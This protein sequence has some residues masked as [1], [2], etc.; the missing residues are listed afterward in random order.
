MHPTCKYHWQS[1][2]LS[3]IFRYKH[4]MLF[5]GSKLSLNFSYWNVICSTLNELNDIDIEWI[6][7]QEKH[8]LSL[9]QYSL[10]YILC[11]F[12]MCTCGWSWSAPS[13]VR[14]TPRYV[15]RVSPSCTKRRDPSNQRLEPRVFNH[16]PPVAKPMWIKVFFDNTQCSV[17]SIEFETNYENDLLG[18]TQSDLSARTRIC[19]FD[20]R[21]TEFGLFLAKLWTY[22]STGTSARSAA[23]LTSKQP[24]QIGLI[25]HHN[26][27]PGNVR[28]QVI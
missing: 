14:Q 6:M 28:C 10:Q 18:K 24:K 12:M 3:P 13:S 27:G 5:F 15:G 22:S 17:L 19:R 1:L 16:T 8:H 7:V 4:H 23:N 9:L 26:L 21:I 20:M 25:S 2:W 11:V